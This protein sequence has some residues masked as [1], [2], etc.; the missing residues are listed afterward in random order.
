[1]L[2]ITRLRVPA[3]DADAVVEEAAAARTALSAQ[4]GFVDAYFGRNLDDPT[5]WTFT[6]RW[7]S[8]GAYRRALSAYAVKVDAAPLY[9]RALD[10]PTAYTEEIRD[11]S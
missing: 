3:S 1:M 6:T 5:L 10:E 8:V 7:E 9:A 4:R 2:V 11:I